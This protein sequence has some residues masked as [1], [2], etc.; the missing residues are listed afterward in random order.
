MAET[1]PQSSAPP[2][3]PEK[4]PFFPRNKKFLIPVI[5]LLSVTLVGLVLGIYLAFTSLQRTEPFEVTL[6]ELERNPQVEML[7][8]TPLEPGLSTIGQIDQDAGVADLM[9]RV[10]GSREK[11]SVRSR[12]ELVDDR[13]QVTHLDLWI[14]E[15]DAGEWTTLIGDPEQLPR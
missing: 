6:A 11:A 10:Q 1:D 8:G 15:G 12:C 2:P 14:G 4:L 7:L 3:V 9:F 5:I 13:W